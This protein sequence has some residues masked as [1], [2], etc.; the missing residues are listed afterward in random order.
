MMYFAF[1]AIRLCRLSI[2]H[3][4]FE[5]QNIM[6]IVYW[7][8][9]SETV[10]KSFTDFRSVMSVGTLCFQLKDL[11]VPVPHLV[12]LRGCNDSE[13]DEFRP[14]LSCLLCKDLPYSLNTKLHLPMFH[15]WMLTLDNIW[16][17]SMC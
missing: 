5:I 9:S 1:V 13:C 6:E 17:T 16:G 14:S 7:P 11:A 3:L 4:Q 10:E 8:L 15:K 2:L 12:W